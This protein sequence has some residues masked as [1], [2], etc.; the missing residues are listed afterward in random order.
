MNNPIQQGRPLTRIPKLIRTLLQTWSYTQLRRVGRCAWKSR[1]TTIGLPRSRIFRP[2]SSHSK[3][4]FSGHRGLVPWGP[5]GVNLRVLG[6]R[7]WF[8]GT[9]QSQWLPLQW[10]RR[11]PLRQHGDKLNG[12]YRSQNHLQLR[13]TLSSIYCD[14]HHC[15]YFV[16]SS[17]DTQ[18]KYMSSQR[19]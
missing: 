17:L 7:G 9:R 18:L 14:G 8:H 10:F 5:H 15:W 4:A 13:P 1:G 3:R 16:T 12:D 2:T 11:V 19:H 6:I